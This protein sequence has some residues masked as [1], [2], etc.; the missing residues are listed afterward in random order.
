MRTSDHEAARMGR[1]VG[2]KAGWLEGSGR[3]VGRK[4]QV[5]GRKRAGGW[6]ED[7]GAEDGFLTRV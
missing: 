6:R 7:A 2:G 4:K 3:V 5:V 1:V